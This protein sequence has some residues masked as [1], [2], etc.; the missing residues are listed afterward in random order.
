MAKDKID[1]WL[2]ATD[3]DLQKIL[4]EKKHF[5]S[6]SF[7]L[8][9]KQIEYLKN[10]PNKSL[11]IRLLLEGA[12]WTD[13]GVTIV[14]L[15]TIERLEEAIWYAISEWIAADNYEKETIMADIRKMQK[16]WRK[17]IAALIRP[18]K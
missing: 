17:L 6:S 7:S 14:Y 18:P 12:M 3:K 15:E 16:R 5:P 11:L 8:T 9:L 13:W 4:T 10:F 1:E 2:E